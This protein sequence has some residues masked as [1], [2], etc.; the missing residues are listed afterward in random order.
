MKRTIALFFV[1]LFF[2]TIPGCDCSD[3]V[4]EENNV[5][6]NNQNNGA[7]MSA[8]QGDACGECRADQ[9]C[10]T[11]ATG[12]AECGCPAG[13]TP[14]DGACEADVVCTPTTCNQQG[15]C[16]NTDDGPECA[17]D[18]GW[19]GEFCGEC[20]A[21]N[22]W[23]PDGQG[24]CTDDPCTTIDCGSR[25]CDPND[26][27]PVC[28]CPAGF[29]DDG[30]GGCQPD[31]ECT[32]T[33]CNGQGTCDD[34]GDTPVC[35]C[36]QGWEAPNC[37]ACDAANGYH[38][39]GMGG[40]TTDPCLPN[41][42][43]AANQSE[44]VA[45]NTNYICECD[46]G[47][48]DEQGACVIDET[49]QADSCSMAGTCDDAGGI[50]DCTCNPGYMGDDCSVCDAA[51]GYHPDGM[52]GCTTDPCL[53][54]PCTMIANKTQ[55][56]TQGM[57]FQ[58]ECAAGYH[59]DGQGGCSDD[60]CVPDLCAAQNQACRV[61]NNM[62]ECY[63]PTCND[64]N[65]C[66]DDT[67][68][69]GSCVY[70]PVTDGSACS[71]GLCQTGEVCTAGVC[72]G[73]SALVCDDANPCTDD[74]CNPTTGCEFV[75]DDT[76]VPDD[77]IGCT[78][79]T[80]SGGFAS[81]VNDNANCDDGQFCNGDEVCAPGDAMADAQGCVQTNIPVAPP[82]PG[83][84]ATYGA[85]DE[86][87]DDFPLNTI[88]AGQAC[89]D[90][91][92]C[93]TNDTC[94]VSGQ[95][96]GT[97]VSCGNPA[98]GECTT[99]TP[100]GPTIDIPVSTITTN[101]T[102]NGQPL[103][104]LSGSDGT[105]N[106]IFAVDPTTKTRH[107]LAY[108]YH[109]SNGLNF[110]PGERI[111][112][113]AYDIMYRTGISGSTERY[114]I[115]TTSSDVVPNGMTYLQKGFVIGAGDHTLN[116]DVPVTQITTNI[117][118]Q[119]QPLAN[120]SGSDGTENALFAVD[121]DTGT[122]HPLAYWYHNSNGLNFSPGERI[123][124]GTYDILYRTGI[125]G[126]EERYA[127]R[128]TSSDVVPNGMTYIAK[129]FV[130]SGASQ[131]LNFDIP[132]STLTT[133]ITVNGTPL[134]NLSGSD[135]SENA[136]FALDRDTGTRHPLAYWYHNS[137][138]LNFSPGERIVSGTY[139]IMY[140]TGISGSTERYAIRTTSSDVV[141][142]GMVILQKDVTIA[143]G[144]ATLNIDV[145]TTTITPNITVNGTALAALSGS[146]GTENAIFAV[147]RDT[148]TRHPIAYW[149]HNSGGL[150]LSPSERLVSGTYDIMFRTG[151]SGSTERYAI[152]TTSSDVVP[153]GMVILAKD[154]VIGGASQTISVD[155]PTT[156]VT[157]DITV[158]GQPLSSVMVTDGTEYGV[159]LVSRE[160]GTRHPLAY[161][162]FNSSGLNFQPS[163]RVV[164]GTYDVMYRT[165]ISGS[166]ERYAIRTTSSDAL[167]N[168]MVL[169]QKDFVVPAGVQTV[170]VDIPEVG[171]L[172]DITVNGGA[173]SQLTGSDGTENG[174][175]FV[176]RETLTRH[177]AAYWY[178]NSNGLNISRGERFIEGAYDVMYRT[179]ISG[180]EER[181]AIRTTSSDVV[182]NGMTYV[183]QCV[184]M[185]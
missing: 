107:P 168:A 124:S 158:N 89:N 138:G 173:L 52:G 19:T 62:P 1:A 61:T 27:S 110:S 151:I 31:E 162:Y 90:G 115:R 87:T 183:A 141:P 42:C 77:G 113:G 97:P 57:A 98:T 123:V 49:C 152:R 20:D 80:C 28:V 55:C 129:D 181:Y 54:N 169:L 24:G 131:T 17:C 39:D 132:V 7:D 91:V 137:N 37:Q 40:C 85:C 174:L 66:T 86:V 155:I 81:N 176:P 95:C 112:S 16:T 88:G 120:L 4:G 106:A 79:D 32:P 70:T 170:S 50:I 21:V 167:P 48:H 157:A 47:Y 122:R 29:N 101:I 116:I 33:T 166:T 134:A 93:T 76:N 175:F 117:T 84:C 46:P 23:I 96:V 35:A 125:S 160:T 2:S 13:T 11:Q 105:E 143:P 144:N 121:R 147:S 56:V 30:M 159:F 164:A 44:C 100:L 26:G 73:G 74:S 41:P 82:N 139:D 12:T 53:P 38:P 5:N 185:E 150:N 140:R 34:S 75:N 99:T 165:G 156:T 154:Y 119:G 118:V 153:N 18:L 59:P 65:P 72:G 6:A 15:T 9:V 71:T 177:P 51:N 178:H 163:E 114:A 109:N 8:D 58:C 128:T 133:N 14:T 145:P 63:T 135:G 67:L 180:S 142:N 102:V 126:S 94:N 25:V 103:A 43:T 172:V 148:G 146:D 3:T 92:L 127:I 182:P 68:V 179:G 60:P 161:W 149:Y 36:N 108:W 104:N 184:L 10:Q 83:P 64:N 171:Y 130:I 136:I 111:V 78:T 45:D 22:G 69:N